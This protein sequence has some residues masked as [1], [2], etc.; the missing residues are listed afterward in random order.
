MLGVPFVLRG[1]TRF[2]DQR[3]VKEA[4]M[5]LKGA[6]VNTVARA[7]V[8]DGER[9]ASLARLDPGCAGGA[10]CAVRDRWESL[11]A[12]MSLADEVAGGDDASSEFVAELL[13]RQAGQ[14]EPT[15]SVQ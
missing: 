14:H 4:I 8:P 12:L 9:C 10:R 13:E 1:A 15:M 7:A 5:L 11:N 6:S 2:F 3:E